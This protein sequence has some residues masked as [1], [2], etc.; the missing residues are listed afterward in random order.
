[1]L[2]GC[3]PYFMCGDQLLDVASLNYVSFRNQIRYSGLVVASTFT[4]WAIWGPNSELFFNV[5]QLVTKSH[6]L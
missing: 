5:I 2:W 6:E 3:V 1:M 4:G